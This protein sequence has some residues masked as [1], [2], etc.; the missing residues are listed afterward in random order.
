MI[1]MQASPDVNITGRVNRVVSSTTTLL[2]EGSGKKTGN[3]LLI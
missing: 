1:G 3:E 2:S